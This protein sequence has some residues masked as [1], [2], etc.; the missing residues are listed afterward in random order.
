M[1]LTLTSSKKLLLMLM[2]LCCN[3]TQ[4]DLACQFR[5]EQSS[6]S[7]ILNQWMPMLK[8]QQNALIRWPQTTIGPI[9]PPYNLLPNPV[10]IIDDA[11]SFIQRPSNLS[12]QK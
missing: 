9:D 2:K 6:V 12:I 7:R 4:S 5:I 10:A 3:F 11:E 1:P 8:V